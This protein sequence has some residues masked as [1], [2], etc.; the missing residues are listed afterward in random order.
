[1]KTKLSYV[2][3]AVSI[4]LLIVSFVFFYKYTALVDKLE[5]ST[6]LSFRAFIMECKDYQSELNNFINTN[7]NMDTEYLVKDANAMRSAYQNYELFVSTAGEDDTKLYSE[8]TELFKK[9]VYTAPDY[10][11]ASVEELQSYSKKVGDIIQQLQ[12]KR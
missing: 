6:D 4:I 3:L 10:S 7:K 2:S 11:K 9:I 12:N 5:S 1:M 8:R